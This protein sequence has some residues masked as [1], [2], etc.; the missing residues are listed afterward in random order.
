MKIAMIT[1][2]YYPAVRGNA[3]TVGRI[4]KYLERAGCRVTVFPLD[5]LSAEDV[6]QRIKAFA[7]DLIHAFH[8]HAGGRVA[9]LVAGVVTGI[10]FL[11]A[12]AI[13]RSP[14]GEVSGHTTA[15]SL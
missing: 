5:A 9:R 2:H 1:P 15:A 4:E 11:G 7:P 8:G 10:G 12:G 14:S 13:L 6:C 3:V